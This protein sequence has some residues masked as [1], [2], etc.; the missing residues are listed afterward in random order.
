MYKARKQKTM[1]VMKCKLSVVAKGGV[2]VSSNLTLR[3]LQLYIC[4]DSLTNYMDHIITNKI[5]LI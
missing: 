1:E 4:I 5:P 2:R 3:M